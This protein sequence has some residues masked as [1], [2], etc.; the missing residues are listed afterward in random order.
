MD[1]NSSR[2]WKQFLVFGFSNDVAYAT[3]SVEREAETRRGGK[4][5]MKSSLIC[6]STGGVPK[7]LIVNAKPFLQE[8]V[9]VCAPRGGWGSHKC[10]VG[11]NW[12]FF[13]PCP[14]N[15]I[16]CSL[17]PCFHQQPPP[18]PF[19]PFFQSFRESSF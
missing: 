19:P 11:G 8:C 4:R 15:W 14:P 2:L 7:L 6:L 1:T 9:C 10:M 5:G 17:P 12:S 3:P 16:F 13:S 18:L